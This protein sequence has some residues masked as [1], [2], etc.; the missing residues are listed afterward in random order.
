MPIPHAPA[1]QMVIYEFLAQIT[2]SH[3]HYGRTVFTFYLYCPIKY[4]VLT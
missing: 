2:I 4:S 1:L 3:L